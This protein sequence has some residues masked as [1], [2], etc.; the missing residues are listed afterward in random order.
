MGVRPDHKGL[1][2]DPCIPKSWD[3]FTAIRKFRNATYN[4]TVT[5]PNNVSKGVVSMIV[6]GT[7]IDGNI[8]PVFNDGKEH[9]VEITLG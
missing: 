5:N 3:G 7:K 2:I 6:D 8:A 1:I 9:S 4:I